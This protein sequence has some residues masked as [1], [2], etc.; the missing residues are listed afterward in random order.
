MQIKT[1]MPPAPPQSTPVLQMKNLRLG[2]GKGLPKGHTA[3]ITPS[4][5]TRVSDLFHY[6]RVAM[7]AV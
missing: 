7:G 5:L 4:L 2:E 6:H 1:R 3:G